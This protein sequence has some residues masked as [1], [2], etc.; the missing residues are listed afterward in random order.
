[1]KSMTGYGMAVKKSE[2]YRTKVEIRAVNSRYLE[3][4]LRMPKDLMALEDTVRKFVKEKIHRGKLDLFLS[5]EDLTS[6]SELSINHELAK[7]YYRDILAL[8]EE[9]G[10][11]HEI[12]ISDILSLDGVLRRD[13]AYDFDEDLKNIV[14]NTVGDAL[15]NLDL[16]RNKEG[17]NLKLDLL[18]KIKNVKNCVEN[19]KVLAPQALSENEKKLRTNIYERLKDE[20]LDLPRLT[21][22]VAIMMDKLSID[23]EITRLTSH[24][25]QFNDIIKDTDPIG[26]KLD[27]LLQE[28]NRE[29][30][31][32][33]SKTQSS[34][35]LK[36]V[37]ELKTEIER[38][39]EQIQNIE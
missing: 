12:K 37:V 34:E 29:S 6:S 17:E 21:T 22:E 26:R 10:I 14:L 8:N 4:N 39:R 38:I 25:D 7:S 20:N 23:E 24:I 33:G 30:N 27:F 13:I 28:F 11:N 15:E 18:K 35:I 1:M 9:L 5:Y 31:T 2:K 36:I 32:I 19:I 3:L 16:M